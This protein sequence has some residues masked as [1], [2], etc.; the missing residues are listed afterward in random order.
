MMTGR[1]SLLATFWHAPLR[2]NAECKQH[3][4][5]PVVD[6]RRW[7]ADEVRSLPDE[8]GARFECVDGELLVS[9][10]PSLS[11][12][13]AVAALFRALDAYCRAGD[14]G[15]VGMAP[16]DLQLDD[17]TLVQ[18]DLFV[19]PFVG[20]RRPVLPA[21]IGRALLVAEVL[22]PTTA[23]YDRVVKRARYQ[24]YGVEYWIVDLDARLVERWTPETPRPEI[25]TGTL[26]WHPAN[27]ATALPID[28]EA[29]FA[30]ALG[31]R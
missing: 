13:W 9:P 28:L 19:L 11:H 18:P 8:P 12:Q 27:V 10:T 29:L 21:E 7:T 31:E 14:I 15:A 5:M 4:F 26:S 16:G 22:S 3:L 23:R 2:P 25:I 30:E 6:T 20:G 24:R 17:A 1:V